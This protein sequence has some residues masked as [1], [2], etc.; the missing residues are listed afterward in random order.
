MIRFGPSGN[1]EEFYAAGYRHTYQAMEWIAKKGLNAFEISFGRGVR[2]GE[3]A[4]RKIGEEAKRHGVALSVHAP[5][6]INLATDEEEKF[7]KNVGYFADSSRAALALG[8]GRVVFH[9]G[10]C[11]KTDRKE[12]FAQAGRNFAAILM[13]MDELGYGELTYCPE[14]MGKENQL[15]DLAEVIALAQL[16]ERVIPA[17]DFAH[18]HARGLGA[19]GSEE[20]F[21]R[22]IEALFAGIGRERTREMH[23][24]FATIEYTA[25]GEKRH[26]TFAEEEYGPRFIHLAPLLVRYDL[27]PTIICESNGTMAMDALT[28]KRLY[29]EAKNR[30]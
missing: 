17:I 21:A 28:M 9:P 19:L 15:G 30:Q 23:V 3:E 7:E 16:D 6:F 4:A 18:L 1:S 27:Q 29:E 26:R 2:L 11:A 24:H 14:T 10:S 12:A 5:Y 25:K 22:V 13:R 20:D 8:A